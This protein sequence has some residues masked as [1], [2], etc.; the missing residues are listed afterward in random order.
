MNQCHFVSG[1]D[2]DTFRSIDAESTDMQINLT[3]SEGPVS[4]KIP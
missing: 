2:P 3:A 1:F 4:V